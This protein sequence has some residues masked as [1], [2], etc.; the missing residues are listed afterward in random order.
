MNTINTLFIIVASI[1]VL[2]MTPGLALF[3]GG[4]VSKRNSVNTMLTVLL[5]CGLS[6]ALWL[7]CGYSLSFSGGAHQLIGNLNHV[8]M[9][10]IPLTALT[11]TKLPVPLFS[12]FQMMFAIITPALFV[13]AVVGRMRFGYLVVFITFWSLLV[14][15]PLVHLV[16]GGGFLADWGTLDFAGGTVVHI[17]AGIT[18]LVLASRVGARKQPQTRHVNLAAVLLGT[19]L[20]WLGWYGFNAGSALAL[21]NAA[22]IATI[23]T[24][25]SASLALLSWLSL[26]YLTTKK[27]TLLGACTGT[28]CGLVAITPAAGY[29]D[30]I[31]AMGIGIGASLVS[32]SYIRYLKP[33]F[34]IDDALDVFGCHGMSGI[35]GSIATGLFATRQGL[36]YTGSW[37]QLGIQILATGFTIIFTWLMALLLTKILALLIPM[38]VSPHT[39][40]VGL[41]QSLHDEHL[42]NLF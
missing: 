16:W 18:A 42:V 1:L 37:R 31:G 30:V 9:R 12:L 5:P 28:V 20:L 23:T 34:K 22:V 41:D 10:G 7:I 8:L 33:Y 19:T 35:W 38:R 39:E 32:F 24:T 13:G 14:Y 25:I 36:L 17:N 40:E 15:Y 3:Y 2:I 6:V 21:N 27:V 11:V 4:Q 29:V 26:E